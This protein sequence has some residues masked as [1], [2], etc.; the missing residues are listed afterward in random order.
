MPNLSRYLIAI[1][2]LSHLFSCRTESPQEFRLATF[3]C[4]VTP[5]LGTPIYSGYQPLAVIEHPLLA[6]GIVLDQGGQRY[7]LCALD[8]CE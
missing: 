8:W 3:Q 5:P 6:K 4:D 7:V 1:M 2:L